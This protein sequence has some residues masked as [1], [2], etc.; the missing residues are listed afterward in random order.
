MTPDNRVAIAATLL[1]R[2]ALRHTPAGIPA[3]EMTL[4]HR[5]RQPEAGGEREVECE[6]FA[7]AFGE[8][9][10]AIAAVTPGTA[11]RCQGFIAR[12]YRTGTTLALHLTRFESTD[13]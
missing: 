6:L 9:A 5:S 7:V 3:I 2:G 13:I 12:R 4:R 10:M 8:L 11:L 1:E